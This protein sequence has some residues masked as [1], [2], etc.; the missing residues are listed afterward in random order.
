MTKYINYKSGREIKNKFEFILQYRYYLIIFVLISVI[1]SLVSLT[2]EFVLIFRDLIFNSDLSVNL[3]YYVFL[4]SVYNNYLFKFNLLIT[5]LLTVTFIFLAYLLYFLI[6]FFTFPIFVLYF[7]KKGRYYTNITK[8]LSKYMR[9]WSF[10]FVATVYLP[11]VGYLVHYIG[12][13]ED[14]SIYYVSDVFGLL[15]VSVVVWVFFLYLFIVSLV[16]Y[17][18]GIKSRFAEY[19]SS[20]DSMLYFFKDYFNY[21]IY[22]SIFI[23]IL[24][25]YY[26]KYIMY[27][28]YF[29]SRN[30]VKE[31]EYYLS[32]VGVKKE[33]IKRSFHEGVP[34]YVTFGKEEAIEYAYPVS[35]KLFNKSE[36]LVGSLYKYIV[37]PISIYSVALFVIRSFIGYKCN[38][39]CIKDLSLLLKRAL[40]PPL[41]LS[42]VS[43][44]MCY[45]YGLGEFNFYSIT[46]IS[47]VGSILFSLG[48]RQIG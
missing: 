29:I 17:K 7:G 1:L 11:L 2:F 35:K 46:S 26:V 42:S 36:F 43:Y 37:V 18:K 9:F 41:F 27:V 16:L 25:P 14:K 32:F 38:L 13:F 48:G 23:G 34:E 45:S 44:L 6:N 19:V 33:K 8:V 47:I 4:V 5:F 31:Y 22:M 40:L 15:L 28:F 20:F 10:I 3:F 30:I 12:I 39:I 24:V 21:I